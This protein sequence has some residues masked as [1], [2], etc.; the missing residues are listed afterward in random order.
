MSKLSRYVNRPDQRLTP[1]QRAPTPPLG[2]N[3]IDAATAQGLKFTTSKKS[4]STSAPVVQYLGGTASATLK[5]YHSNSTALQDTYPNHQFAKQQPPPYQRGFD[6]LTVDSD[7]DHTKSDLDFDPE[8]DSQYRQEEDMVDERRCAAQV[9]QRFSQ[10]V[11]QHPLRHVHSQQALVVNPD[12][13]TEDEQAPPKVQAS[14]KHSRFQ[15]PQQKYSDLQLRMG[16]AVNGTNQQVVAPKKRPRENYHHQQEQDDGEPD[17]TDESQVRPSHMKDRQDIFD[18]SSDGGE[19]PGASP[20]RQRKARLAQN[21]QLIGDGFAPAPAPVAADYDDE[22]LKGMKYSDLKSEDWDTIPNQKL[23]ELPSQVQGQPLGDRLTYYAFQSTEELALFYEHLSTNEWEEAGDLL[24][25]KFADLLKR[26][27]A[28]RQEKRKLTEDFE[29]EIEAR[30]K[31]VRGKSDLLAKKLDE[32]KASG[33]GV[34]R[35]KMV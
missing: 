19:T 28:K 35:G 1:E 29:A 4:E 24:I 6:E 7:W 12:F 2:R 22:K 25:E 20:T 30:E 5:G 31:A 11:P 9:D 34:L 18:G 32:M 17:D 27:K 16:Q 15:P 33:E 13:N 21:S 8:D 10:G 23:F 3:R 26:L 14:G